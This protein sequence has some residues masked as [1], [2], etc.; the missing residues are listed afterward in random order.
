LTV[1]PLLVEE[2]TGVPVEVGTAGGGLDVLIEG[3]VY[4]DVA[5]TASV[6]VT[7]TVYAVPAVRPPNV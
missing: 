4:V 2:V 1:K 3:E 6:D 7:A 5:P